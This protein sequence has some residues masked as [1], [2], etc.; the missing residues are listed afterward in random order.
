MIEET[1]YPPEK[2]TEI[3]IEIGTGADHVIVH[4]RENAQER[5]L[6]DVR[7]N[8]HLADLGEWC[9][10]TLSSFPSSP[11]IALDVT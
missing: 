1:L 10:A 2:M 8:G 6:H 11:W 7:E 4:L 9:P 3:E 5:D